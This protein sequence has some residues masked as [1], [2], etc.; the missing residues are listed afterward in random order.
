MKNL[1]LQM[2][3]FLKSIFCQQ[4]NLEF[5]FAYRKFTI[6]ST[7]PHSY[8]SERTRASSLNL[9]ALLLFLKISTRVRC[10]F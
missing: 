7:K 4:A 10:A 5:L 3:L 9:N 6:L 2:R 8:Y 1:H